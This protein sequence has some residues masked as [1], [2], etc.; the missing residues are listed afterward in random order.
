MSRIT[1]R[2]IPA[3]EA[4][5]ALLKQY[6]DIHPIIAQVLY[7]RGF[8]TPESAGTFLYNTRLS[9]DPFQMKDM[10]KAVDRITQAVHDKE[11]IVIYGD[12]DCDGVTST[13]LL[14]G[15]LTRL[16]ADVE[17]YIPHR[18]DEGY[19]LNTDALEDL[20]A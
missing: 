12:F 13:T 9:L 3:P 8:E 10:Q 16:K 20:A 2:W 1:K 17:A 15:I 11:P 6:T 4:A 19:G 18:V 5:P 7:N 14:M